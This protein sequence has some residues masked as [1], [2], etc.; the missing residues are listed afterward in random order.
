MKFGTLYAYWTNEWSGD[1]RYYAEKAAKAGLD[2]IEIGGGAL[3]DMSDADLASFK[4]KVDDLGLEVSVNVGPPKGMNVASADADERKAG[5]DFLNGI[6]RQMVKIDAHQLIGALY[7][8]WPYDFSDL[9]KEAMWARAVESTKI[10]AKTAEECGVIMSEEVLNRFESNLLNTCEEGIQFCNDVDSPN[11]KLLL[12]TF[13]MNIE[14][15]DIPGAF[16]RAGKLLGHVHVGESNRRVPGMGHLPWV[17]IGKAL[18]G[19]GYNGYVVM[20][21]FMK[22]GGAV[23]SDIKVWRD[24]SNGADEA[25]MDRLI[26][27]STRFLRNVFAN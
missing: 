12:D 3:L 18:R 2:V 7:T 21:P 8:S 11:V 6:M 9:D 19:I 23:G 20:E 26:A 15:D 14:E 17:E 25:E 10:M 13:H 5:I 27:E 24:L 1:Y 22:A 16:R 4:Q